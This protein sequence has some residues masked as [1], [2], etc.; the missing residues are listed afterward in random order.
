MVRGDVDVG[1]PQERPHPP[2]DARHVAIPQD[3][4]VAFRRNINDEIV[5]AGHAA[6]PLTDQRP[7]DRDGPLGHAEGDP[8]GRLEPRH[9]VARAP[10]DRHAPL[11]GEHHS[12]H[13]AHGAHPHRREHTLH[14][15]QHRGPGRRVVAAAVRDLDRLHPP[16]SDSGRQAADP[17]CQV[18]HR[19]E[20]AQDLA[21]DARQVDRVSNQPVHERLAH[22]GADLLRHP[23]L[24]L[25]GRGGEVRGE[26]HAIAAP[27]R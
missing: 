22:G 12:V 14:R 6:A 20:P 18:Q 3:D 4:H 15:R 2:D 24:R 23:I 7:H 27:E 1:L 21:R 25:R 17:P 19:A 5:D 8:D 26:E 16:V 11:L 13:H 9:G 10:P